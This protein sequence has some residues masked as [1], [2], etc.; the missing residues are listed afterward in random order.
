M[1]ACKVSKEMQ[2]Y[3]PESINILQT[4]L[5]V[6]SYIL[7]Y[8]SVPVDILAQHYCPSISQLTSPVTKLSM[9]KTSKYP[10]LY[11]PVV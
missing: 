11:F 6:T 4:I 2:S 3:V 8:S 1:Q 10:E 7:H 5:N 9:N